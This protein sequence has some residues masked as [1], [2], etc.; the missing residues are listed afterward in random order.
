MG[1]IAKR[2][3]KKNEKSQNKASV[4]VAALTTGRLV[5]NQLLAGRSQC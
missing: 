1:K 4:M 3:F 2:E 5:L